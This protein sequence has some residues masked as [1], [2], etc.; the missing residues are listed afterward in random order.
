[1][2]KKYCFGKPLLDSNFT[3]LFVSSVTGDLTKSRLCQLGWSFHL[4]GPYQIILVS[5][6]TFTPFSCAIYVLH[7]VWFQFIHSQV[8]DG[9]GR[10]FG[11]LTQATIDDLLRWLPNNNT[12]NTDD[13]MVMWWHKDMMIRWIRSSEEFRMSL[14]SERAGTLGTGKLIKV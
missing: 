14:W 3:F 10:V 4:K 6:L 11:S 9:R 13:Y 5:W 7:P 12:S 1:M 8:E 2:K